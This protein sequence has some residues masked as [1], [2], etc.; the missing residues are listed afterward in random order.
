MVNSSTSKEEAWRLLRRRLDGDGDALGQLLADYRPWLRVLARRFLEQHRENEQLQ[1]RVDDSD[2]VQQ[3]CLSA[4]RKIGQFKGETV[5]EFLEWLR[6]IHE[7]NLQNVVRRHLL[8]EKRKT[9]LEVV[10]ESGHTLA[11]DVSTPSQRLLQDERAV[12]LAKF[13][14]QLPDNQREAVRLRYLEGRTLDQIAEQLDRSTTAAAGLLKR[15]LQR[16]RELLPAN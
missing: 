6:T 1:K 7:R 13:I 16:L 15:G 14:E 2:L 3:T 11:V 5:G 12:E 10:L 4:V 9:T 8:T